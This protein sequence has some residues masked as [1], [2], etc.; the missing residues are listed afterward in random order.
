MGEGI[1]GKQS[2]PERVKC[3]KSVSITVAVVAMLVAAAGLAVGVYGVMQFQELNKKMET[4]ADKGKTPMPTANV[5]DCPPDEAE[6]CIVPTDA[7][8][9]DLL[10]ADSD[11]VYIGEWGIKIHVPEG[12]FGKMSYAYRSDIGVYF[13]AVM[14]GA[15]VENPKYFDQFDGLGAI[16]RVV[17]GGAASGEKVYEDGEY[18]YYYSHAQAVISTD[19]TEQKIEK[20]SADKL[21]EILKNKENYS[22]F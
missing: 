18:D 11:Y 2:L 19:A 14:S 20:D 17:K 9:K 22:K 5:V 7:A 3:M 15:S 13:N 1:N 10:I 12:A 8:E 16:S 21:A 4:S 6:G